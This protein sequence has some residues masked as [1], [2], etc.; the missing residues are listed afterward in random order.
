MNNLT[1]IIMFFLDTKSPQIYLNGQ[2]DQ[3]LSLGNPSNIR[4]VCR[5]QVL[6]NT[7]FYII[8][9]NDIYRVDCIERSNHLF[10]TNSNGEYFKS[11]IG[12][13]CIVFQEKLCLIGGFNKKTKKNERT[14]QMC[15]LSSPRWESGEKLNVARSYCSACSVNDSIYV[16]GGWG[17]TMLDSLEKYENGLWVCLAFR[18]SLVDKCSMIQVSG[19]RVLLFGRDT[20]N[21]W[22][23]QEICVSRNKV[24][25]LEERFEFGET[26][27][28][29][30]IYNDGVLNVFD[31]KKSLKSF[32]LRATEWSDLEAFFM[33]REALS[34]KLI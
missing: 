25:V 18:V 9:W 7:F 16:C 4:A 19:T 29:N 10:F 23:T 17:S 31:N 1:I 3:T 22:I 12:M 21:D 5:Y 13:A 33:M 24:K 26:E 8:L 27:K 14:F 30:F 6:N 15:S 11:F 20:K 32:Q 2:V 28:F 34:L